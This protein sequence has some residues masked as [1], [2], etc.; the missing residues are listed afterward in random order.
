[1]KNN[2][3]VQVIRVDDF[4][5]PISIRYSGENDAE[6]YFN[7]SINI[8][9]IIEKL[10][11]PIRQKSSFSTELTVLDLDADSFQNK[12]S[13][14]ISRDTIVLLEGIFLFRKELSPCVDYYIH[15]DIP[16]EECLKRGLERGGKEERYHT[17][18]IPAQKKYLKEYP[19]SEH[20]DVIIDNTNWEYP[21][22]MSSR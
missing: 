14:S 6:N 21:K 9:I 22:I 10:L 1:M 7:L 4:H 2:Y 3:P 11:V 18:Y 5:N 20:A 19:P 8:N 15:L 12:R 16:F 13:Y 17:K